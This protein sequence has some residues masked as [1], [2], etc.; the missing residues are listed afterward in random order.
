MLQHR[1][2]HTDINP[3][4]TPNLPTQPQ[5]EIWG[6]T[7]PPRIT[8]ENRRIEIYLGDTLI[9]KSDSVVRVIGR[10]CGT[11]TFYVP[12]HNVRMHYLKADSQMSGHCKWRGDANYFNVDTGA[13]NSSHA[14]CHYGTPVE[15]MDAIADHICFHPARV[16]CYL[17]G[18]RV[19]AERDDANGEWLISP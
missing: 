4:A 2:I 13:Q 18:M 3:T 1:A 15:E 10:D 16:S 11:T 19:W 7:Q 6:K 14:A 9:A 8:P 12:R 17:D 5:A